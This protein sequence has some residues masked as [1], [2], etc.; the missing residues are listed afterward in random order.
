MGVTKSTIDVVENVC[1][2]N[3]NLQEFLD[4]QLRSKV[5]HDLG[6]HPSIW[7]ENLSIRSATGFAVQI[8]VSTFLS[9]SHLLS[10][11]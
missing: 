7:Y 2:S 6:T 11:L 10:R 3:F 9:P 8:G 1:N 5:G 4:T